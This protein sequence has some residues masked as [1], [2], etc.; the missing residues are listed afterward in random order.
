VTADCRNDVTSAYSDVSPAASR[1]S[2]LLGFLTGAAVGDGATCQIRNDPER[3]GTRS[4]AQGAL[5]SIYGDTGSDPARK[6][7]LETWDTLRS[8]RCR[9]EDCASGGVA[10]CHDLFDALTHGRADDVI[11]DAR[12]LPALVSQG[13]LRRIRG[14][15]REEVSSTALRH[16]LR[17]PVHGPGAA[18]RLPPERDRSRPRGRHRAA[19]PGGRHRPGRGPAARLVAEGP[20]PGRGR[21]F[22]NSVLHQ[23]GLPAV[24][25]LERRSEGPASR[26]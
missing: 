6:N 7:A 18:V 19:G 15:V 25:I 3:D 16:Q 4:A 1:R 13:L 12:L 14:A 2:L 11:V 22:W 17:R 9:Y 24:R 8:A 5:L 10:R 23:V 20:L 21:E 26:C